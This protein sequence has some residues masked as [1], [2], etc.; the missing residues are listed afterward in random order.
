MFLCCCCGEKQKKKHNRL[1]TTT[2][3]VIVLLLFLFLPSSVFKHSGEQKNT[4]PHQ[5]L[6]NEKDK[7]FAIS[8]MLF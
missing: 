8:G 5:E 1:W 6:N 4:S 2:Q 7:P 3:F